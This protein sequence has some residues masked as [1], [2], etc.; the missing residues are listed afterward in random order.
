MAVSLVFRHSRYLFGVEAKDIAQQNRCRLARR[1]PLQANNERELDRLRLAVAGFQAWRCV[2]DAL[3]QGV[4]IRLEP[5]NP[6][7]LGR[8]WR[9]ERWGR[10]CRNPSGAGAPIAL[11]QVFVA[12]LYSQGT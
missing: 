3:P 7:T 2:G 8:F 11:R 10:L 5:P 9:L 1:H 12:I 4:W 6:I